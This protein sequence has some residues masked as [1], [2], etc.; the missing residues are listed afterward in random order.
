MHETTHQHHPAMKTYMIVFGTLMVLLL[1]S[2]GAADL[3]LGR[4]N[5]IAAAGIATCK[6]VL[7]LLFFMHVRYSSPLIWL[8]SVAGFFWLAI[9][10]ALTLSDYVTR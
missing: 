6:A 8:F 3:D 4:W 10:F 7:I 9:L 5:F 1:L 2:V